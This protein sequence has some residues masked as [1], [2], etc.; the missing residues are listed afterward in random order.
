MVSSYNR[1][2]GHSTTLTEIS[3]RNLV[4]KTRAQSP[5]RYLKRQNYSPRT[6]DGVDFDDLFKKDLI[7]AKV[8]VGD[9]SCTVA[10]QYILRNLKKLMKVRNKSN[11]NLQLVIS[12]VTKAIDE[13][14]ILVDCSCADFKYRYAYWAT[15]YGYKYG[16]PENRPTKVTN[17]ADKLGAQ[18]KHL[19]MLLSNKRWLVK[20]SSV[21]NQYLKD[22]IETLG[23]YM[24]DDKYFFIDDEDLET[25]YTQEDKFTNYKNKSSKQD[26]RLHN[27]RLSVSPPEDGDQ[28]G[29]IN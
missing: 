23:E 10:F 28:D 19:T 9:Y 21:I 26:Y 27:T 29:S 18:C 12:A 5:T 11:V 17:P 16:E 24:Y 4:G 1:S 2:R 13:S 20:V 22:N 25:K 3:R 7:V 15:K 14:D 8:S 6:Y